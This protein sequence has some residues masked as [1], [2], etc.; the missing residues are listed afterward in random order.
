MATQESFRTKESIRKYLLEPQAHSGPSNAQSP[1]QYSPDMATMLLDC[2]A[3]RLRPAS[4]F[5][6]EPSIQ[7][8]PALW[9]WQTGSAACYVLT[10]HRIRRHLFYNRVAADELLASG[11]GCLTTWSLA[12]KYS[13]PRAAAC[14]Y[15]STTCRMTGHQLA[16][17]QLA[18]RQELQAGTCLDEQS[19]L[20]LRPNEVLALAGCGTTVRL[21]FRAQRRA[22]MWAYQF[23]AVTEQ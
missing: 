15:A 5:R 21:V 12:T 22:T 11:I 6:T 8:V 17:R 20:L 3:V 13:S 18:A 1:V 7:I 10:G 23:C 14:L 2:S 16:G 4:P 9:Q 19:G